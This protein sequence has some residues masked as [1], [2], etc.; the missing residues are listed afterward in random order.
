[1]LCPCHNRWP[2]GAVAFDRQNL[3]Q[4]AKNL[5]SLSDESKWILYGALNVLLWLVLIAGATIEGGSL[6]KLAY[7]SVLFA[8]CSSPIIYMGRLNGPYAL[9]GVV[10]AGYFAQFGLLDAASMFSP[11]KFA[12]ADE[13]FLDAG[14]KMI[15]LGAVMQ[16]AG[17]HVGMRL[18]GGKGN[19]T[20][21]PKDWPR[22]LLLPMGVLLWA[23]GSSAS[24]YQSLVLQTDN[25]NATVVAG[26][27][28]LG[29]W[30]T[31]GLV[32]IGNYAGPLGIVI[33]AYWWATSSRSFAGSFM[34]ILIAAQAVIGWVED[35][36]EVLLSAPIVMLL[37]RFVVVG[38]VPVRW[39]VGTMLA[40][41]LAFPVLTA[42]RAIMSEE[43]N[44][45]RAQALPRT[46]EL[47]WRAITEQNAALQGK[48]ENKT[49]TFLQRATAKASIEIFVAHMGQDK[50]YKMGVTLEPMLYMFAPKV[51]WSDKSGENSAQTFNR[52]FHLSE[53]RDAYMSPSHIGELYW[54]FGV[55]GVVVGMGLSGILI[56]FVCRRFDLSVQ[57]SLT[58]VLVI[59]VTLYELVARQEGQIEIQYVLWAR[60]LLLIGI[61]HWLLARPVQRRESGSIPSSRLTEK[62]RLLDAPV[63]FPNLIR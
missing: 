39:L 19:R 54:N 40:I 30:E 24:L 2:T 17:F 51:I 60:T 56:G 26:L 14:E 57:A 20:V 61:L 34:L 21:V 15:L 37:T 47:L 18:T 4:E 62:E 7:V 11:P 8:L 50:P 42:K 46:V 55:V 44:L 1:M 23:L 5:Q 12:A 38:K 25:S 53:D 3:G 36:K 28:R 41:V 32:L 45:N 13:V 59:I 31:S 33:L 10:T 27:T 6:S 49:Q 16:I 63:R 43:L 52:D 9:L 29:I 35:T 48:F 22:A 58:R